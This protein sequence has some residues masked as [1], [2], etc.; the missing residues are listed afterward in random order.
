MEAYEF[1]RISMDNLGDM[2]YLVKSLTKKRLSVD[3]YQKKY[4]SPW[5][6]KPFH[7]WLAYEK[8]SGQVV[9]VAAA[10][11]LRAV[12]PDGSTAPITQLT[13]TFTLPAHQGKGLMTCLIQK[14]LEDETG[15]GVRLFYGLTNQNSVYG[16]VHKLGFTQVGQMEYYEIRTNTFPLEALCRRCRVP[17]LHRWWAEKVIA[18]YLAPGDFVLNN[19]VLEEGYAGVLHDRSFFAYKSFSF[20]RLCRFAGVDSWLKF[21]TGLLVGDVVLPNDCTDDRFEEWLSTLRK[22]ARRA[23]LRKI[24]FQTYPESRLR[25][26][27]SARL[28]PH[29]SWAICCLTSDAAMQ[30]LLEKMRFGYG[31]FDTF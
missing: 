8:S 2:A 30:P 15:A 21:E 18:S 25:E 13:E 5:I 22:I 24:I 26:K 1:K 10:L 29:P 27:L 20:N 4:Q 16:F 11:P 12:L 14:T 6:G 28:Q 31:D 7:G 3:Y 23:G 17:R 9:A 19:S